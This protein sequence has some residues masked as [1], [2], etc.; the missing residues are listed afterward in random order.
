[1]KDPAFNQKVSAMLHR[2]K[3]YIHKSTPPV[4]G[5][6]AREYYVENSQLFNPKSS[7][8]KKLLEELN[9]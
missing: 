8:L 7:Y 2:S 1:M 9:K 6:D 5:I 3:K 4:G